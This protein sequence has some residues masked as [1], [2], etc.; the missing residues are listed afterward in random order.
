MC[1]HTKF[2]RSRSNR[3]GI[4]SNI[5]PATV[6]DT[7]DSGLLDWLLWHIDISE[8]KLYVDC[9]TARSGRLWIRWS[10]AVVSHFLFS[11]TVSFLV[12]I[13]CWYFSLYSISMWRNSIFFFFFSGLHHYECIAPLLPTASRVVGSGPGRLRRSMTARGSRGCSASFSSRSSAVVLVVS[14]NTQKARKSRSAL[15][16]HCCPFG[17]YAVFGHIAWN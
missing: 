10:C 2:R 15:C 9:S 6:V 8:S 1:Y 5:V 4:C 11:T 14:S 7:C 3:F 13:L 16:L 17:Q 12:L